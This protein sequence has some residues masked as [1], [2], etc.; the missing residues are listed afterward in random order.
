M[1]MPITFAN[2][3][4]FI[5]ALEATRPYWES[6]DAKTTA[7][8]KRDEERAFRQF[9]KDL[10]SMLG[11][12]Y[13]DMK[14]R[15]AWNEDQAGRWDEATD[16]YVPKK[17]V[18]ATFKAPTCPI[19]KVGEL[20]RVLARLATTQQKSFKVEYRGTFG[21]AYALLTGEADAKANATVC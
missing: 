13:E 18:G 14:A 21:E 2:R 7:E 1:S 4:D 3:E 15:V 5:A 9:H 17:P 6:V 10:E 20:D 19:S 16:T 8:H 11:V 12:S